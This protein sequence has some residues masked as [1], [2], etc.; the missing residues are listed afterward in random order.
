M[1]S[2]FKTVSE[3][4]AAIPPLSKWLPTVGNYLAHTHKGKMSEPFEEHVLLVNEYFNT[5][6][7]VHKLDLVIDRLI[8]GQIKDN[9]KPETHV[10]VGNLIKQYFVSAIHFHDFGKVNENF[11]ADPKKMNNP[12]FKLIADHPIGTSHSALGAYL[13]ILK[14]VQDNWKT[15]GLSKEDLSKLDLFVLLFSYPIF[16]HH[17]PF[18]ADPIDG[19]IKF[20]D[21]AKV[22]KN[23][24]ALYHFV[25]DNGLV[26]NLPKNLKKVY[27]ERFDKILKKVDFPL[28]A[29]IKLNFS[30][31][32]ASDYLATHEYMSDAP[33]TDF[34]IFS[35]TTRIKNITSHFRNFKHNKQ[36][37]TDLGN[38]QFK[39]PVEISNENL[40]SLRQEMAVEVI[41]SIRNNAHKSLF[42]IEAPTG[43]G[44]TNLSM[45]T[46]T[47]LLENNSELT[48]A[49]YVF[50]F[51]TLITQ[52]YKAL[53][54]SLGLNNQELIE[55]H[56]KAGFH[57]KSEK[58]NPEEQKDGLF[59][60]EKKDFIDNLFSLYPL[61]VLSHVR[62]FEILK[63]NHKET[64]YQLHRLANSVI[65]IDELQSYNP[66]I[67]D[68]ML[69]FISQ[70]AHYFN[71]RFVLMSA[72]LPKI[73][74]LQINLGE[75]PDFIELLPNSAQYIQNPNF[76]ERVVFKFE[77][78]ED[79][80]TL[81]SLADT[82]ISKSEKYAQENK[83]KS[84]HTI[85]EFIYKKSAA[86]FYQTLETKEHPFAE[87]FVL[88]GT[89]LEPRRRQIINFLK[90][91]ENRSKNILLIT[92]QVVEAGV[93]IDMDLGF[94]NISLI[95]SD[96]QLAGRVNRNA[97]KS[98][99]EVYLFKLD[100]AKLLYQSDL[101]YK[102]T[103][104]SISVKEYK[105]ILTTK[106]FKQLY[107]LVFK[108]KDNYNTNSG[109]SDNFDNGFL[110]PGIGRLNYRETDKNFRIIDQQNES[111]F[112]P[113][114]LP[115]YVKGIDENQQDQIFTKDDLQFLQLFEI[116][117][118]ENNMI[119][120]HD[121][122]KLYE[123]LIKQEIDKRRKKA[124][125]DMKGKIQF[126]TLQSILSKFTFALMTH[127][128]DHKSIL[129]GFGEQ[130]YGFTF[131][132]HWNEQRTDGIP[133]SYES[134]L[135]S[136]A[137]SDSAFI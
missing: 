119:C 74:S 18:L 64:N 12:L 94:K 75:K 30:L 41:Q 20:G 24:I 21:E 22:M 111:V 36:T 10:L 135:N 89:I 9:F 49:Y 57:S 113:I 123:D 106:D 71:M 35:D 79:E 132:T 109:W 99:S 112:V 67:W 27:F 76:A 120:G 117:P 131:F 72:T 25:I 96:E 92:T 13:F 37:F 110:K 129:E 5:L 83:S 15:S 136:R 34:G 81:E 50:P 38:F 85:I 47:E 61:T 46:L 53:Q 121:V 4:Q 19:D 56:S 1:S 77:L 88:S 80:I 33:T 84:V 42:Y 128:K 103:R 69:F 125:F 82:V 90:R 73:S 44:K 26:E 8:N 39:H 14:H 100:D 91:S 2:S 3:I 104:E 102:V 63:T 52:T 31:L 65:V 86:E 43:G 87:I 11:Q 7:E 28:F 60:D 105:D 51:T 29:L 59:G 23:Y 134:G 17:A 32:T 95:D 48:K 114:K 133:Y 54:E 6:C 62:F 124:G 127:S 78:F 116:E 40:N 118:D 93:D 98:R 45:I 108:R 115:V 126:K 55:L 130:K 16:K 58:G 122:W 107:Q 137:F 101:R 66:A 97:T 68:K 70:Y